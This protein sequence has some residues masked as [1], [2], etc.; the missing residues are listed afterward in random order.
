[1]HGRR[2]RRPDRSRPCKSMLYPLASRCCPRKLCGEG[3]HTSR[4]VHY[5]IHATPTQERGL[6][7]KICMQNDMIHAWTS[8]ATP[9]S[10][11]TVQ[12]HAVPAR[13]PMLSKKV[14]RRRLLHQPGCQLY[15]PR[16]SN[17]RTRPAF[18]NLQA[19]RVG[20]RMDVAS[21][22]Q[23]ASDCAVPCS[24]RCQPMFN[25]KPL[26]NAHLV[27]SDLILSYLVIASHSA[28][29]CSARET[30][31]EAELEAQHNAKSVTSLHHEWWIN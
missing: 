7:L 18:K 10:F 5:I 19:K 30:E 2:Q 11:Q 29:S 4:D 31:A 16:N 25:A 9:R 17:A 3:Y 14:V 13:Q 8:P 1:M 22:A 28:P 12:V 21:Y 6:P 20:M 23:I 26:L 15:N 24:P 27:S